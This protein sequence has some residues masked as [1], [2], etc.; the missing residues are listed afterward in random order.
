[1]IGSDRFLRND[2][3]K[4]GN[5]FLIQTNGVNDLATEHAEGVGNMKAKLKYWLWQLQSPTPGA[6]DCGLAISGQVKFPTQNEL[7]G[8]SSGS[9][10]YSGL[11]HFGIPLGSS[12]GIWATSA[13]TKIGTNNLF[14]GWP[15]RQWLQ[16]YELSME[17]GIS[18]NLAFITQARYESPLFNKQYLTFNY[19]T[20]TP[21]DQLEEQVS[22][23]WNALVDWRGSEDIGLSWRWGGGSQV[24]FLFIEDWGIGGFDQASDGLYINNAPDFQFMTQWHFVF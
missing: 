2:S 23:G 19:T 15:S 22:S 20:S 10:D 17:I 8:L 13:V 6:C 24:N 3:P 12:S 5:H 7:H 21:Q 16:M 9:N 18:E 11:V 1:M 4:F 14:A